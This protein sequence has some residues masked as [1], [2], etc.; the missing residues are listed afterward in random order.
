M[1]T[2]YDA[3]YIAQGLFK[4]VNFTDGSRTRKSK[5]I[6]AGTWRREKGG[7]KLMLIR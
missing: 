5:S 2:N 1:S 6:T 7:E 3:N 4:H